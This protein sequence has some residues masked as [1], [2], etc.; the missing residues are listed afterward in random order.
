MMRFALGASLFTLSLLALGH[1]DPH[2]GWRGN[3]TGL[4]PNAQPPLD[5]QRLPRGVLTDL[6]ARADRPADRVE[7]DSLPLEKGIIR[8][9]LV[10]GPFP[11][12]DS[13]LDFNKAQ[14]A[15][16]ANVQPTNQDKV[17][18]LAWQK[19]SGTIDD[20]FAFGPADLPWTD[21][22]SAMGGYKQNQVAYAHTYL[23]SPK[24][25]AVRAVV[26]HVHGM[27]AW[28][29]GKE[30]YNSAERGIGMGNYYAPSRVELGIYPLTRAPRFELLLKPG[31]NRLLAKLA[32]YNK[33]GWTEHHFCMRLMDLP[34]VAYDSKNIFWMTELP[35]RS[36]ATPIVVGERVFVMA[37]PDELLCLDKQ[38]G[39]ILWSAASNYYEALSDEERRANPLFAAKVDPLLAELKK[40]GDFVQRIN[41]R[42]EIQKALTDIDAARFAWKADGHFEAHFGIVGFT[43]PT[44][45]SDGKHVW[46]WCGNG[47]AACY[48]LEGKR[49]WI[50][51]VP[52]KDLSY[53]CSPAL[54]DGVFAVF[55]HKLIGLDA[56]T[57]K[58]RWEREEININNG[59]V[60][61]A[62]LAGVPVF[63]CQ[64]GHV[65]RAR[66]GKLLHL[67]PNPSGDTGWAPPVIL[68]DHVY[69]PNYGVNHLDVVDYSGMTGDDWKPKRTGLR[70]KGIGRLPNGKAVD[71][72]T[73]GSPLVLADQAYLV[74]IYAAFYA[75]DL[76][77]KQMLY[78]QDT[79]MRGL[80]H[81]NA[82]PVA[83]SPTLVGKHVVIQDNQGTALVLQPGQEYRQTQR[84][85]IATQLDRYWPV[86]AQ[87]T[88]GYSPPVPDG[89][90][91]FIRGE[92]YLYCIGEK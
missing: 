28:L 19:L 64:R 18:S 78:Q 43:T 75:F 8:D 7:A 69:Q 46:V 37:E 16:E 92:R 50:T 68:G 11:V 65:V 21:L 74:D 42:R 70:T 27:K 13:V 57:G 12:K 87:E 47:V 30:V 83:S 86:P 2:N 3:G 88:I 90:R 60:L 48:T 80:F 53:A 22:T 20:P 91:M 79:G 41:L 44:P 45:V 54:A 63:V 52:T 71:R 67:E 61:A 85:R 36:N 9:W 25:G 4:W 17:G 51:R 56:Q 58:V 32:T 26:D 24:G 89:K 23:F 38:T 62:N 49:L 55:L 84:N 14:L 15:D 76:K 35:Q 73:A 31:W 34:S 10:L 1:A 82:L 39:K 59:A 29:N 66:D 33:E 40:S 77:T 5:W 6:R 72:W 81:Y